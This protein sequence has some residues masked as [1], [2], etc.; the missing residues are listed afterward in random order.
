MKRVVFLH[1]V[2][3]VYETFYTLAPS[4][5]PKDTIIDHIVD[6]LLANDAAR[7]GG[8]FTKENRG[9]LYSLMSSNHCHR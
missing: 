1:T 3:S 2:K 7:N 5:L 6:E 9:R 4:Q 8:E